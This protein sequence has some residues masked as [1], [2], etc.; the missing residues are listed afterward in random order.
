MRVVDLETMTME[1]LQQ[2][3]DRLNE[4]EYD[5]EWQY[6]FVRQEKKQIY[7][8]MKELRKRAS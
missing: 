7:G 2:E 3:V 8:Y 4:E 5:T 6:E 1:E